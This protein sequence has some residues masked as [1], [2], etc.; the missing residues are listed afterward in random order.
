MRTSE[1][2]NRKLL[3]QALFQ[4]EI[5]CVIARFSGEGD[6]GQVDSVTA[7]SIDDEVI[8][9]QT[10]NSIKLPGVI[11]AGEE[12]NMEWAT[13][14]GEKNSTYRACDFDKRPMTLSRLIDIV[15]YEELEMAHSG[16]EIDAGAFGSVDIQVP[17]NGVEG[18]GPAITIS[19]CENEPEYHDY[20]EEE[21][22]D[23]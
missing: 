13:L 15:V 8:D 3:L 9:N 10:L 4:N 12:N 2:T 19:Y 11:P 14:P 21:Y 5:K 20:D 7:E 1:L 22:N 6:S 23:E 17:M 18:P 16:W